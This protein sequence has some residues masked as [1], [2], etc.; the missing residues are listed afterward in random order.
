MWERLVEKL[1]PAGAGEAIFDYVLAL[2]DDRL[3]DLL[4]ALRGGDE[5]ELQTREP[6]IVRH[7]FYEN[8]NLR[9]IGQRLYDYLGTDS[10]R[11]ELL[12]AAPTHERSEEELAEA[13]FVPRPEF[14]YD[15]ALSFAGEDRGYVDRVASRLKT[16]KVSVFY[17]AYEETR[18]WGKDLA[19][20]LDKI[21]REKARYCVMFLSK[22]YVRKMWPTWEGR[23]ALARAVETHEEYI[24]PVRLDGAKFPGL[25]PTIKYVDGRRLSPEALANRILR[26]LSARD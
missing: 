16:S 17:D 4:R 25:R 9:P 14:E 20:Y 26:K 19:S 3:K 18:M 24:L 10:R 23:A 22:D 11:W 6:G 1:E 5:V 8:G 12:G 15:V 21:F 7:V 13:A 2:A